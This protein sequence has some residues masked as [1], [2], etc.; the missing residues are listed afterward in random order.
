MVPLHPVVPSPYTLHQSETSHF[1]GLDLK[2]AFFSSLWTPVTKHLCL[3]LG[4]FYPP[5]LGPPFPR[6][7]GTVDISVQALASNLFSLSLTKSKFKQ[8]VDNLHLCG[9][10]LQFSQNNISILLNL[11][12]RWG[13]RLSSSKVQSSTPLISYLELAVTLT[14]KSITLDRIHKPQQILLQALDLAHLLSMCGKG[15]TRP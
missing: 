1:S 11:L 13:Y 4:P 3:C 7:S 15:G 10:S 2:G 9:L 12:S 5:L 14:H 6:G 8:Y